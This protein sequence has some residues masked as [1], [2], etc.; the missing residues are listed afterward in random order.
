MW[1]FFTLPLIAIGCMIYSHILGNIE[2]VK[3]NWNEYRCNPLYMPFAGYIRPDISTSENFYSCTNT[4]GDGILA[5][6][7]DGIH[8]LLKTTNSSL[9]EI[10]GPLPM[11]R[12]MFS[13]IRNFMLGFTANTLGKVV[14]TSSVF[15]H[16][17]IKLQDMFRRFV[18]Q[19]YI[20]SFLTYT[21]FS[22][23][24]SFITLFVSILKAFIFVML[25]IAIVLA[26][27]QPELLAIVL[28]IS[29]IL[30]AAGA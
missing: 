26:L 15:V 14:T 2:K 5:Y 16:F 30:A 3:L 29:S 27:F 8:S 9:S 21:L 17:L 12:G 7:L 11:F 19:G 23:V 1:L 18:G 25:A 10:T 24:E 22:F 4:V 6:A 13:K 20:A 28:A